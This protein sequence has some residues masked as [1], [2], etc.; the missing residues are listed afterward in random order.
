MIGYRNIESPSCT[1][2][3]QR[4]D[5]VSRYIKTPRVPPTGGPLVVDFLRLRKEVHQDYSTLGN[6]GRRYFSPPFRIK[7]DNNR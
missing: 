5:T 3:K 4:S 6:E 7:N 1:N 2:F